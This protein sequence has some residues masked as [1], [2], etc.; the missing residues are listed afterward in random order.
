MVYNIGMTYTVG[1]LA[2]LADVSVR[3]LRHYD[4]I[5]LLKPESIQPNGYREYGIK[6]LLRLQQILLYR[7]LGFELSQIKEILDNP[8]FDELKALLTHKEK[9][10][11]KIERLQA[12]V[13]T[14]DGTIEHLKGNKIMND[15]NLFGSL[16]DNQ[17]EEYSKEAERRWDAETVRESN[18][19]WK[20]M[21]KDKKQKIIDEGNQIYS[22]MADMIDKDPHCSEVQTIVERWRNHIEHF[23]KPDLDGLLGLADLYNDDPRFKANFDRIDTG[24]AQFFKNAVNH[25]VD[26]R[27]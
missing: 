13:A 22:D 16:S 5:G 26:L 18:A 14:V 25:Y 2:S 1:N 7:E 4:S 10:L 24:L 20:A 11:G 21:P 9:L 6:S 17:L 3:T 8:G 23:W 19:R 15:K 27:R 12:I